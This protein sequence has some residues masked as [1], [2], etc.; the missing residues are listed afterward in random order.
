MRTAVKT[1]L[2]FVGMLGKCVQGAEFDSLEEPYTLVGWYL[3]LSL[4]SSLD[5]HLRLFLATL[6]LA[7][8]HLSP[9]Q[10]SLPL[11]F[12]SSPAMSAAPPSATAAN[13]IIVIDHARVSTLPPNRPGSA[14]NGNEHGSSS[15]IDYFFPCSVGIWW[16]VSKVSV[17][18]FVILT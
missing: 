3:N 11:I 17:I 13:L 7:L 9:N 1:N 5:L 6:H 16:C 8:Q 10:T 18:G 14:D 15:W 4:S 12:V 2:G